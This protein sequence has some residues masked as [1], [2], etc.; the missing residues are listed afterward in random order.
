MGPI[1]CEQVVPP[2]E[3]HTFTVHH[4]NRDLGHMSGGRVWGEDMKMQKVQGSRLDG[5]SATE[6]FASL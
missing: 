3:V 2:N 1:P 6:P 4:S 5:V